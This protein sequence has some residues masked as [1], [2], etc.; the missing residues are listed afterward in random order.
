MYLVYHCLHLELGILWCPS[1]ILFLLYV[2]IQAEM[3]HLQRHTIA[4]ATLYMDSGDTNSAL[5]ACIAY[6]GRGSCED[7]V[8]PVSLI[9]RVMVWINLFHQG[10]QPLLSCTSVHIGK[11][12]VH[13][14]L[15]LDSLEL[16]VVGYCLA[17][18]TTTQKWLIQGMI[19]GKF[20]RQRSVRSNNV[21][22]EAK[23]KHKHDSWESS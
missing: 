10:F 21:N 12:Y 11:G 23:L 17:Y 5:K 8:H 16:W 14:V 22:I 15:G 4:S 18:I 2:L 6:P 20:A 13:I 9:L 19:P 3:L 7:L 1:I